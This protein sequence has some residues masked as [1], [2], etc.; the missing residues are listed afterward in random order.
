MG[1]FAMEN[2]GAALA[3]LTHQAAVLEVRN[4]G[5]LLCFCVRAIPSSECCVGAS[6]NPYLPLDAGVGYGTDLLTVELLP[7]LPMELVVERDDRQTVNEVDKG[8]AHIALILQS[9]VS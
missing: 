2:D 3:V 1:S 6:S 4:E 5:I 7:L 8:V 9:A